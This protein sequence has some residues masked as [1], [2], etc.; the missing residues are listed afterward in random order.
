[1][2]HTTKII[3]LI[4]FLGRFCQAQ[5]SLDFYILLEL[6]HNGRDAFSRPGP[7]WC[8]KYLHFLGAEIFAWSKILRLHLGF[9]FK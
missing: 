3:A 9:S 1:M 6:F 2:V 4:E 5:I 8:L 7:Y